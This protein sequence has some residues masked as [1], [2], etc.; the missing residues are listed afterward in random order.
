MKL[1]NKI[2]KY[3]LDIKEVAAEVLTK[4]S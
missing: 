1:I 4:Y 2:E 3:K